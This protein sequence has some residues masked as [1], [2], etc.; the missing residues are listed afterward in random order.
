MNKRTKRLEI[1]FYSV[2]MFILRYSR[3]MF[4][5]SSIGVKVFLR[6]IES[7]Q[8]PIFSKGALL[9]ILIKLFIQH[10]TSVS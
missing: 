1:Y 4:G 9:K 10:E 6:R 7:R 5:S 3:I 2:R 8:G